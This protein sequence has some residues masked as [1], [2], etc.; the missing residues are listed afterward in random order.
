MQFISRK[1]TPRIDQ[2]IQYITGLDS[3]KDWI[4]EAKEYKKCLTYQQRG[5]LH[6]LLGLLA[7]HLGEGV[8]NQYAICK[9]DV[10]P[11]EILKGRLMH[12]LGYSYTLTLKDGSEVSERLS[13]EQLER[14]DYSELIEA[15][16]M[17][18]LEM[19]IQIPTKEQ[20]DI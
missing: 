10:K 11:I 13:S 15:A 17:A 1:D 2:A 7:N 3:N 8:V 20:F 9:R 19:G 18:C 16:M 12:S 5:Y 14:A 6:T 4:I